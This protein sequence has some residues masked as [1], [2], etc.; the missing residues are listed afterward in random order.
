M[1]KINRTGEIKYNNFGSKMI[2]AKYKDNK[3]ILCKG[4]KVY[5]RKTCIFV[6]ERINL[7]F[8][9]NDKS[10]GND[11][12]GVDQL[13]SGNYRAFCHDKNGKQIYLG[14]YSTK[15]EAFQIYK[16]IKKKLLK[17]L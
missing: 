1:G 17:K 3:D 15:E 14:V 2:I 16:N 13:P 6:P 4:N 5:S 9:K 7:L 10:R 11:P 12:I 8:I